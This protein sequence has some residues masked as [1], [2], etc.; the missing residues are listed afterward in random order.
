MTRSA[1]RKKADNAY[2]AEMDEALAA[3]PPEI[4]WRN[5]GKGV[6]VAV[7]VKD[8][9]AEYAVPSRRR[10]AEV[11]YYTHEEVEVPVCMD[12]SLLAAARTE[13]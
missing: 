2:V 12:E 1:Y 3:N 5:N 8:P 11:V 7:S 9:R 13:I 10:E 6:Q 4:V